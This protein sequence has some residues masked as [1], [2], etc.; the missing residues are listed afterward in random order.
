MKR[1]IAALFILFT[2]ASR[3]CAAEPAAKDPNRLFYSANRSYGAGDYKKALEEYL[4]VLD[5]GVENGRL[6]YNI[7]NGFFKLGKIGYAILCYERARRLIPQDGDLKSNLAYAKTM[8]GT[9]Y[10]DDSAIRRLTGYIKAP[11]L[12]MN[13]NALAN[14]TLALYLI[15]MVVLA[16]FIFNRIIAR[17]GIL[18]FIVLTAIFLVAL[19]AVSVRYYDEEILRHGIIIE[20]DVECK[21]EPIDKSTTYY[22]LHEGDEV[23]VL[24]T[25]EGWR[26]IKRPDG[27]L[28]WIKKEAVEII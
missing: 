1:Y 7:G 27:K 9:S 21:Y 13:L 15:I 17:K 10:P 5:T 24:T 2:L 6:H 28:A 3:A 14:L 23:T 16:I 4:M 19:S 8:A 25:R 12:D 11:F 22:K 18:L 20:K 26:R